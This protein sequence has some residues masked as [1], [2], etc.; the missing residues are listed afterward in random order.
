VDY[1]LEKLGVNVTSTNNGVQ[2]LIGEAR[3]KW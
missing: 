1:D 3:D 2:R